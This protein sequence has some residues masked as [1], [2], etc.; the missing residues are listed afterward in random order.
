MK[1]YAITTLGCKV[2]QCESSALGSL[3]EAAGYRHNGTMGNADLIVINTCTVTGKAAMQSRQAIRQAIRNHPKAKIVVTGCYAQTAP[4]EIQ[5]IEGVEYVVGHADKLSIA[6]ML[7][8]MTPISEG[9]VLLH[10]NIHQTRCFD[11]M[12]SV[13]P[14]SR[15][16]AFLKIQDGCDTY[17][18]YCIVP[19]ARGR[20][21]SMPVQEALRHIDHL[22][23]QHY[24]EIVLTGIHLGAYGKDLLPQ[25]SLYEFIELIHQDKRANRIRLSS[26]EPTEVDANLIELM[27]A[28]QSPLCPHFHI[29]LQSGDDTI[30]KRMGRPYTKRKFS[31]VILSIRK[32]L[33]YAAIGVDVLVG[34]P[35]EDDHAFKQ[36]YDLIDSLDVTYLHVFPFSPRDGT[37]AATFKNR[38]PDPITKERCKRLRKLGEEK[39]ECFYQANINRLVNVLVEKSDGKT[40]D[41]RGMSE[42]YIPVILP[43]AGLQENALVAARIHSIHP[44]LN[45]TAEIV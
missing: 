23:K 45:V 21:R 34:F 3:L 39:K 29:P 38:V 36:T 12:P 31:E 6:Q 5:A 41:S 26:I 17:C 7:E 33:P 9:P 14:E 37:P 8:E 11:P 43:N 16:R 25:T 42:N 4:E 32:K 22:V 35:G 44:G 2:N 18:T 30:L 28:P 13:A 24:K 40:G 10:R 20:S 1:R 15:T 19:H 27:A